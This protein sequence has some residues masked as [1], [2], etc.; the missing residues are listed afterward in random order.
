MSNSNEEEIP[1]NVETNENSVSSV[2]F[3]LKHVRRVKHQ[4]QILAR[5]TFCIS[6]FEIKFSYRK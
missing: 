2:V 5:R 1:E 6:V 4:T 3:L